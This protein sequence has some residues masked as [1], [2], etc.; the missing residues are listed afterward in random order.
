MAIQLPTP[1]AGLRQNPHEQPGFLQ[2]LGWNHLPYCEQGGSCP[3]CPQL[4]RV[5]SLINNVAYLG[6]VAGVLCQDLGDAEQ[7]LCKG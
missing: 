4:N 7:G 1:C 6:I 3:S 2:I 5:L